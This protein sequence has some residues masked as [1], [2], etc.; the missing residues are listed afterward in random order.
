MLVFQ[1]LC[2]FVRSGGC[3]SFVWPHK[4]KRQSDRGQA[5]HPHPDRD[6]QSGQAGR[7]TTLNIFGAT[8]SEVS[9]NTGFILRKWT[10]VWYKWYR[11]GQLVVIVV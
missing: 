7:V 8:L 11:Y 10:E 5:V 4:Q 3:Q 6:M 1:R 2:G 9:Q